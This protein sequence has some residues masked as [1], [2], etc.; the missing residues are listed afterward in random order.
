METYLLKHHETPHSLSERQGR[1][2]VI[3]RLVLVLG[4]AE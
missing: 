3:D 2:P 1:V 4:I